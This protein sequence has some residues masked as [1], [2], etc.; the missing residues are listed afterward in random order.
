MQ[1]TLALRAVNVSDIFTKLL[2]GECWHLIY[3]SKMLFLSFGS[4]GYDPVSQY[5]ILTK[6]RDVYH[7]NWRVTRLLEYY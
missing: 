2:G 7:A 4:I 6:Y 3:Y 1:R 5:A